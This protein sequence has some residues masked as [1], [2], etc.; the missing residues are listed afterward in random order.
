MKNY[1][2]K[3]SIAFLIYDISRLLRKDFDSRVQPLGLTQAQW[4][5][6]AHIARMEGC[7]QATLADVLEIK[8]ITLCRLLDKLENANLVERRPNPQDRRAVQIYISEQARPRLDQMKELALQ[9]RNRAIHGLSEEEQKQL[10][11]TLLKVK[12]NLSQDNH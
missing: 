9:T 4:R 5:A 3:E 1:N 6:I 7:S 12:K 10:T 11:T 8:P 2:P